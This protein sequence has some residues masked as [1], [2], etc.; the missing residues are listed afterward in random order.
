MEVSEWKSWLNKL[1]QYLT[2]HPHINSIYTILILHSYSFTPLLT[3][4]GFSPR[5]KII[6]LKTYVVYMPISDQKGGDG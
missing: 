6:Q 3:S 4:G 2:I 1:V 5:L